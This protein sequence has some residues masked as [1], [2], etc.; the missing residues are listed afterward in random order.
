MRSIAILFLASSALFAAPV[1]KEKAEKTDAEAILGMW[2]IE[3][4]GYEG[5]KWE[6]LSATRSQIHNPG[7]T[8]P[9]QVVYALDSKQNPK[10]FD[11]SFPPEKDNIPEKIAP[12]QFPSIYELKGDTLKVTFGRDGT[13]PTKFGEGQTTILRRVKK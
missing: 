7:S 13:R 4:P 10:H 6:F 11:W 3:S 9:G 2:D 8:T 12:V 1:P 5:V